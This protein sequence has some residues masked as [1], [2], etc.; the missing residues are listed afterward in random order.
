MLPGA[1]LGEAVA[2]RRDLPGLRSVGHGWLCQSPRRNAATE[3]PV[4]VVG[5]APLHGEAPGR[6]VT[7]GAYR[8]F[9]GAAVPIG[10]D[11]VVMQEDVRVVG[12]KLI[13]SSVPPC[14][15]QHPAT[16]RRRERWGMS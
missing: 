3:R 1:V 9:T 11:S 16:G 10:A 8:I 5:A 4:P 15:A 12:G 13:L 6:L 14:G 2:A 7:R